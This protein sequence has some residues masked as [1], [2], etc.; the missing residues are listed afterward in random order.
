MEP[1]SFATEYVTHET[2][3]IFKYHC[4]L[5]ALTKT[6]ALTQFQLASDHTMPTRLAPAKPKMLIRYWFHS[7]R[8]RRDT[9]LRPAPTNVFFFNGFIGI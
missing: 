5:L 8:A 6:N 4:V 2:H 9:R 7:F 3:G 1:F